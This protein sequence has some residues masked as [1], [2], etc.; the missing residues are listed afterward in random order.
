TAIQSDDPLAAARVRGIEARKRLVEAE[1]GS[2]S[3]EQMAE[4]LRLSRQAVDK[5]RKTNRLVGLDAGRHGYIYPAWQ[6]TKSGML[7]GLEE[8]L[9]ELKDHDPWMRV[10]FMLQPNSRLNDRTPLEALREGDIASVR[11]AARALGEH[12]AA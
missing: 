8:V 2:L 4:V 9:A 7:N 10:Q 3:S 1:G 11:A 5:R 12:G 6:V